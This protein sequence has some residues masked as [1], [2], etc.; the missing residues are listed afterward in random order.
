MTNKIVQALEDG[1]TKLGKTLGEDAGKA[2]KDLYHDTGN[3][4]K[5]VADNHLENDAKHASEL[6]GIGKGGGQ[7][8]PRDPLSSGG[9]HSGGGAGSGGREP[10][11]TPVGAGGRDAVPSTSLRGGANRGEV[12]AAQPSA[13]RCKGGDPIDLISGE[14]IL[15]ETDVRLPGLLELVIERTHVS[16]YRCGH[17]FG[18]SWASTLDQRLEADGDGLVLA[19]ADGM[20]LVYPVPVPGVPVLPKHGPRWPLTWDGTPGGEIDV[21]D[22]VTGRTLHFAPVAIPA[23]GT[24]ACDRM[25]LPLYGVSDR[26]GHRIEIDRTEDGTPVKVWHSGGYRVAVDTDDRRIIALRLLGTEDGGP[27]GTVLR[28]YRYDVRGDLVEVADAMGHAARFQY[29]GNGRI[30]EWENRLCEL[31][32]AEFGITLTLA[33]AAGHREI[34]TEEL[35]PFAEQTITRAGVAP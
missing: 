12:R 13:G 29:A 23:P 8:M 1:A 26:N 18:R 14:M 7:D 22:P 21:T 25:A 2:V 33:T 11:P 4:L 3:R 31:W 20:L 16:S 19:T 27:E 6:E 24:P 32:K 35:L 17:W 28:R 10:S 30:V 9:T 5:R 15:T 34:T